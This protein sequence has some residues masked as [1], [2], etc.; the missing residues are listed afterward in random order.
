MTKVN[1]STIAAMAEVVTNPSDY[2][3]TLFQNNVT[4]QNYWIWVNGE[5]LLIPNDT[6]YKNLFGATKPLE[7]AP[8]FLKQFTDGEPLSS[9]AI[10]ASFEGGPLFLITNNQRYGVTGGGV[11]KYQLH[12]PT[13]FYPEILFSCMKNQAR[14][15]T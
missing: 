13:Q 5:K 14:V 15:L 7:R 9:N 10:C 8:G 11:T 3:G 4:K 12:G 2:A 1:D 6:V